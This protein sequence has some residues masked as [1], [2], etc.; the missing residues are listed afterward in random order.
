M[1]KKEETVLPLSPLNKN[2]LEKVLSF[3]LEQNSAFVLYKLPNNKDIHLLVSTELNEETFVLEYFN[4]KQKTLINGSSFINDGILKVLDLSLKN[5]IEHNKDETNI[6]NT[7]Q[8]YESY[9]QDIVNLCKEN[10]MSKCVAARKIKYHLKKP[11]SLAA[12]FL[13][14]CNLYKNTFVHLSNSNFGLW[15]G[16]SPELLLEK[17]GF[18]YKTVSLA[19]TKTTNRAWTA[20][21]YDEQKIVT[22]YIID[23]LKNKKVENLQVSDVYTTNASH[24]MHLKTDISCQ[25]K[26]ELNILDALHP[27]PA[28]CG[29]PKTEAQNFIEK[30]EIY[31]RNFYAGYIGKKDN[32]GF[33]YVNLRC[34]QIFEKHT[35]IYVGA[36]ITK[37]SN[38]EKEWKETEEKSKVMKKL[39]E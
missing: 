20:K 17:N 36:G 24:L 37:D 16:A 7:Q 28:V 30:S 26:N 38:P 29:L 9:V 12:T 3:I 21:E 25:T 32:I 33:Y 35:D 23:S 1:K 19:G 10:K 13:K 11:L 5:N 31:N 15:L 2:T 18:S 22:N 14:A 4:S 27:T 39:L 6:Y 34:M 8:E